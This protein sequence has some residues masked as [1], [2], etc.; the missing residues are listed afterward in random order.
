MWDD[1]PLYQTIDNIIKRKD[2]SEYVQFCM[3]QLS[4]ANLLDALRKCYNS[5]ISEG[6][7]IR[8]GEF[9]KLLEIS[10]YSYDD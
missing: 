4:P 1:S 9:R 8:S 2:E 6:K 5:G 7:K 3:S 10:N